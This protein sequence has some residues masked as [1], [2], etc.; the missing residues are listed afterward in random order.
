MDD[1]RAN[2]A[3]DE[4]AQQHIIRPVAVE[5]SHAGYIGSRRIRRAD[6]RPAAERAV[7]DDPRANPAADEVAKQQIIGAVAVEI[8]DAGYVGEPWIRNADVRPAPERAV[9][10]DPSADPAGEGVAKEQIIGPIALKNLLGRA[11]ETAESHIIKGLRQA[12]RL[13]RG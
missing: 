4:V 5:I 13:R 11:G 10:E 12:L 2:Q 3:A 8:S 7:M 6:A 9:T 1:P